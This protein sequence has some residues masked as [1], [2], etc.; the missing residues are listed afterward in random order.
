MSE[1][2]K[3]RECL[4]VEIYGRK[5][6]RNKR[7]KRNGKNKKRNK[8]KMN[9]RNKRKRNMKYNVYRLKGKI[10]YNRNI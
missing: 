5:M 10:I 4:E 6:K 9:K 1:D 8:R 7:K 3:V 2:K